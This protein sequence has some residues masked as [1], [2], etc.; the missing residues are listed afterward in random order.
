M[1][2]N[3]LTLLMLFLIACLIQPEARSADENP[4]KASVSI[5]LAIDS[6]NRMKLNGK[7]VARKDLKGKLKAIVQKDKNAESLE[8]S[9]DQGSLH[10]TVVF[11]ID[12]ANAAGLKKITLKTL[13]KQKA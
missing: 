9:A 5:K 8:I 12:A 13:K 2:T 1:H 10:E 6:K 4:E 11:A 3:R 7:A